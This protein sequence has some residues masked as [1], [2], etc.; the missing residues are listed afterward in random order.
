MLI[1]LLPLLVCL[2]GLVV[3]ALASNPKAAELGRLM[4]F[5]GL[6][7]TLAAVGGPMV[8]LLR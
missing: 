7:F 1:I 4:F 5:A 8:R 6:L 2:V 3:Y